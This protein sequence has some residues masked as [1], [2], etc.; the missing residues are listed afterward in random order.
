MNRRRLAVLT[1]A[2]ASNVAHP[3]PYRVNVTGAQLVR[4]MLA[5]P[6]GRPNS[7]GRERAM[8]YIDCVLNASAGLRWC[9]DSYVLPHELNYVVVEELQNLN[10]DQLKG[11]AV[12][13]MR[14]A[15]ARRYPCG[16]AR[17]K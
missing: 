11:S 16:G 13:L 12:V 14:G 9:P 15:L 4:D 6:D 17:P 2:L 1:F 5:V 7:I 8:G 10:P 3:E